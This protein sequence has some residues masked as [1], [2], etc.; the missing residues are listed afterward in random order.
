MGVAEEP[1]SIG[2]QPWG[3]PCPE[4]V[5]PSSQSRVVPKTPQ[6]MLWA[7]APPAAALPH[8]PWPSL[9]LLLRSSPWRWGK[10]G[11]CREGPAPHAGEQLKSLLLQ[12]VHCFG[13]SFACV[14]LFFFLLLLKCLFLQEGILILE[15]AAHLQHEVIAELQVPS[16]G[17]SSSGDGGKGK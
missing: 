15:A 14:F 16:D 3:C 12:L 9:V 11:F 7:S 6:V 13:F 1:S 4:P 10:K 8:S 5:P 2:S 17:R